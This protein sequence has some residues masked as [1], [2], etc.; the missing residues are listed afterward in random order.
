M[1]EYSA[2][3][4]QWFYQQIKLSQQSSAAHRTMNNKHQSAQSDDVRTNWHE[5]FGWLTLFFML[6]KWHR[7][8]CTAEPPAR[9]QTETQAG[10]VASVVESRIYKNYNQTEVK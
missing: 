4:T 9:C 1:N 5:I 8:G 10:V 7:T 6:F 2:L 3:V